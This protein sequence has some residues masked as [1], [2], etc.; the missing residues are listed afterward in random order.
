MIILFK[1]CADVKNCKS[2]RGFGFIYILATNSC[3]ARDN[4]FYDGFIKNFFTIKTNLIMSN[5]FCNY[6]FIYYR[7]NHKCNIGTIQNTKKM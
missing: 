2:F 7:N 5:V 6:I 1:Y 4:Y 3:V